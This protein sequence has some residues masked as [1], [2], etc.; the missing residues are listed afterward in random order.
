MI[1]AFST[2]GETLRR[3]RTDRKLSQVELA[4][5]L[6]VTQGTISRAEAGRDLRLGTLVEIARFLD[7]EPV[8]VPRRLIPAI[9]AILASRNGHRSA[10]YAGDD[11][12]PYVEAPDRE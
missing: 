7:L 5:K 6:G 3:A 2:I 4:A 12:E 11:D 1:V 9:E 10:I 8:L